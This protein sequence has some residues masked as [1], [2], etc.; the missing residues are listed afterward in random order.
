[1]SLH[2]QRHGDV[3]GAEDLHRATLAG[4]TLGD[5]RLSGYFAA[6]G[7]KLAQ[8][9]QVDRRVLHTEGVLE[10]AQLR[11]AH[12]QRKLSTFEARTDLVASLGALGATACGLA[13]RCLTTTNAASTPYTLTIM[14]WVAVV[15]TPI[16]LLY[17]GWTLWV[18][19]RRIGPGDIPPHIGLKP[20]GRAAS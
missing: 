17:Q 10:A 2:R 7:E 11:K 9:G 15:F 13:L 14:T 20:A 18:F 3:T 6:L 4:N 1:M 19:R 12:V 16:V 8:L 5:Q